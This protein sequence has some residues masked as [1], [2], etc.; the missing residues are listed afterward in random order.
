MN[1]YKDIYFVSDELTTYYSE[2]FTYSFQVDSQYIC[3]KKPCCYQSTAGWAIQ[4]IKWSVTVCKLE[5]RL[6]IF[7]GHS[8]LSDLLIFPRPILMWGNCRKFNFALQ[9]KGGIV[10]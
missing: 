7:E 8:G 5:M 2:R 3:L 9:D 4:L 6:K 10:L 1:Q